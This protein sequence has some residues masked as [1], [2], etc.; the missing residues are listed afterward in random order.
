[1]GLLVLVEED[2]DNTS[3]Y[4]FIQQAQSQDSQIAAAGSNVYVTWGERNQ[5]SNEPVLLW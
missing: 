5:T 4:L 2:K 3:D 1:M